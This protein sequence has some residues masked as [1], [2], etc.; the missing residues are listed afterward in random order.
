MKLCLVL[1]TLF[2]VSLGGCFLLMGCGKKPNTDNGTPERVRPPQTEMDTYL[3]KQDVNCENNQACPNYIAKIVVLHGN[4]YKFCTG[5]LTDDNTVATSSSCIPDILKLSGQDCS[6]DV[7]FF[8]PKTS[9][10]PAERVGCESVLQVSTLNGKDPILWRD[11]VAYLKLSKEV[12]NRRNAQILRDG[13]GNNKQFTAW[14]VDQQDEFSAIIKKSACE[15]VH[16]NYVNPLVINESSPNMI[17]ADC[18]A[19]NGSTGA[20]VIDSRG[21]VRAMISVPM[22]RKLRTYLESTGLLVSGLKEMYHATNFA[23][24]STPSDNEMLDERE[25]LKDLNYQKVDRIR[26]EMLSTNMLFGDLRRKLEESLEARSKYVRFGVKMIPKGDIQETI[27]YPKCFKPYDSWLD[28]MPSRNTFVDEVKLPI[29]SFKRSMDAYGRIQ[30]QTIE[31]PEVEYLVQFSLKNLR[32][33]KKSSVLMW[34]TGDE[35]YD[36]FPGLTDECSASLL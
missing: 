22:D 12:T 9:N 36:T 34:V 25:C 30:G 24:A 6:R 5:F 10:R 15:S 33:T 23:C 2:A 11:D 1:K 26:S 17:F 21:K 31:K 14:M 28:N 16:N 18:A 8:F 20:P 27:I 32:N 35:G 3:E 29:K 7:F 13:V 4:D 19:T